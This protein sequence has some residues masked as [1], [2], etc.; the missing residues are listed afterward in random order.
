MIGGAALAA[1]AIGEAARRDLPTEWGGADPAGARPAQRRIN[2]R[3]D[4]GR[5]TSIRKP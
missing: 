4:P 1:Q 5:R 3:D 2:Q